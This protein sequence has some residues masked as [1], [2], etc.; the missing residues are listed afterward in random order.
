[1]HYDVIIVG[2]GPGGLACGAKLAASGYRTLIVERKPVI[3]PKSC[4][5]G[6][7]WSGLIGNTPAEIVEK[8]FSRQYVKSKYQETCVSAENPIIATVNR[9]KFG[10]HM[11][12]HARAAGADILTS[13]T[14]EKINDTAIELKDLKSKR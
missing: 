10:A 7:T 9:E 4:A 5:G 13:V 1:M 8:S 11:A 3:G 2:A 14:V 6:I 12:K